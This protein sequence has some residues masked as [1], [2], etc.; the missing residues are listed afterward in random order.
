MLS[1]NL[2]F[3]NRILSGL[4][5]ILNKCEKNPDYYI[6]KITIKEQLL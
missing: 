6:E 5:S 2:E 4:I 1:C 3:G